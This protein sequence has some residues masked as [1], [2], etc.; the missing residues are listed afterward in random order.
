MNIS[1]FFHYTTN[2][3]RIKR[4]TLNTIRFISGF[5]LAGSRNTSVLLPQK[6]VRAYTG[7]GGV[8]MHCPDGINGCEYIELVAAVA[9]VLSR[10][11]DARNTFLLA[12]FLQSVSYQLFTLGAFK[13]SHDGRN[14]F[15]EK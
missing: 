14:R 4:F 11:L 13:E 5:Q 15:T 6:K 3:Q 10:E 7:R 8:A 2:S 12:E 1:F 9:I